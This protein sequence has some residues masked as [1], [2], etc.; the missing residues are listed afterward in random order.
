MWK[1]ENCITD[2]KIPT[3]PSSQTTR[4]V[5]RKLCALPIPMQM[6]LYKY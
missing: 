3:R 1:Q 5:D 6:T 2:I 4:Q